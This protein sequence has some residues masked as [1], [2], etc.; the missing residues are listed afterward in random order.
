[1][2]AQE[3]GVHQVSGESRGGAGEPKQGAHRG[4]EGAQGA[5]LPAEDR[6]NRSGERLLLRVGAARR[7]RWQRRQPE[8]L[9]E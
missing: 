9:G 2:P 1:M 6:L 5:V 8:E 4:A 3:E 7:R